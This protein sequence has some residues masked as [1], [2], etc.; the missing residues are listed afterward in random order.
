MPNLEGE[1]TILDVT[2]EEVRVVRDEAR[3]FQKEVLDRLLRIE[4]RL[5][6][7]E[8]HE[9]VL[10]SKMT[11]VQVRLDELER[12]TLDLERKSGQ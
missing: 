4:K 3:T 10:I 12:R 7:L 9:G 2:F 11:D 5:S 6:S 8:G 1:P